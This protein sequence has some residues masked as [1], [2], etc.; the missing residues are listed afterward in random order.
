MVM[1]RPADRRK[2]V[3]FTESVTTQDYLRTLLLEQTELR[4][5]DI[6]LFRGNNDSPRVCRWSTSSGSAP[7]C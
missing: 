6:T 1:D 3:I 5:E 7:R 2:V 4:D